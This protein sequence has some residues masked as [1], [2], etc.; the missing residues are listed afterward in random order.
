MIV[1]FNFKKLMINSG[2]HGKMKTSV[3]YM[4]LFSKTNRIKEKNKIRKEFMI[5]HFL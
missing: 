1:F 3:N 2:L 5:L 4:K